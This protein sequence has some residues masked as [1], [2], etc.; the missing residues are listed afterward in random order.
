VFLCGA[1]MVPSETSAMVSVVSGNDPV[2]DQGWPIGVVDV[3]NLPTRTGYWIGP[4]FGSGQ[5]MF[6]YHCETTEQFNEALEVF[7]K[8]LAPRLEL[9]IFDGAPGGPPTNK[10][11]TDWEFEAWVPADFFRFQNVLRLVGE[12]PTS[13]GISEKYLVLPVPRITVYTGSGG[14]INLGKVKIPANLSV[15]DKRVETS[16]YKASKGGVVRVTVYD[17]PTGQVIRGAG[18][19][20]VQGHSPD[21]RARYDAKTDDRGTAL[22]QDIG[23]GLYEITLSAPGYSTRKLGNYWNR[24]QTLEIYNAALV[25][26]ED[27]AGTVKDINGKPLQGVKVEARSTTG[28]DGLGYATV[29][30]DATTD[31]EGRFELKGLP[32]GRVGDL[33]VWKEGYYRA[34]G[35]GCDVPT[36]HVQ[37]TMDYAGVIRG[38]VKGIDEQVAKGEVNVSLDPEGDPIGKWGGSMQCGADGK[39]E[40]AGAPAGRY[41]LKA[42]GQRGV[43]VTKTID[44]KP[45]KPGDTL[46]IDLELTEP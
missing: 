30:A 34:H 42:S 31:E 22:F 10:S 17:M 20:V 24:G 1:W 9:L 7:S 27:I 43:E 19:S 28:I 45:A 5:Y 29:G 12:P 14:P 16:E 21:A 39:F 37:V 3:A 40:F 23:P 6:Q 36:E 41:I 4:G 32:R 18:V 44:F 33:T 25:I 35:A 26:A 38:R 46:E 2:E 11:R 13:G 8:I 15:V